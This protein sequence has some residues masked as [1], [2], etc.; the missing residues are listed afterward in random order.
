MDVLSH[1]HNDHAGL[2]SLGQ[3]ILKAMDSSDAAGRDNQFDLYD[4]QMRRHL[5]VVEE[6]LLTPLKKDP[7]AADACADVKARHKELRREL[8]SLDRPNKGSA[9][10]TAEFR[11]FM[12]M[13]EAVC[14]RHE[15]LL[16][17]GDHISGTLGEDYTE[18]K[19]RRM[20]GMPWSWNRVAPSRNVTAAA[21]GVAAVAGAALAATRYFN[22]GRRSSGRQEDDFELRLETD[23][24]LRLIS[25]SKV[26]GTNVVDRDG[27][28]IGTISSFMVDKYTGRVA[29]AVMSFGG[30]MGFGASLFPLPWPVLDYDERAGGYMLDISKEE[31]ANAP[32]FEANNEPEF[33][34]DYRREILLFYRPLSTGSGSYS[35]AGSPD[36]WNASTSLSTSASAASPMASP[37]PTSVG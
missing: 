29:Y 8:S 13:F 33:D 35:S 5:A 6:V 21:L 30:T 37:E 31:M 19:L 9:E 10:W 16:S 4:I 14:T 24:N 28:K 22:S 2:R 3:D 23:E 20:K 17:H 15:A 12:E 11:N 27:A 34:A 1:M 7:D 36:S 25:S 18:A 26:E 32:R